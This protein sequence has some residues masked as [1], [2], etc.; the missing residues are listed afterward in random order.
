[1]TWIVPLQETGLVLDMAGNR[2]PAGSVIMCK[3]TPFVI[4]EDG[5]IDYVGGGKMEMFYQADDEYFEFLNQQVKEL[6]IERSQGFIKSVFRALAGSRHKR[7]RKQVT[8]IP[9]TLVT[10]GSHLPAIMNDAPT[11]KTLAEETTQDVFVARQLA[12]LEEEPLEEPSPNKELGESYVA[13]FQQNGEHIPLLCTDV[14]EHEHLTNHLNKQLNA[15]ILDT[16]KDLFSNVNVNR[17]QE[18]YPKISV[19][20]KI[21]MQYVEETVINYSLNLKFTQLEAPEVGLWAKTF[22]VAGHNED[23]QPPKEQQSEPFKPQPHHQQAQK[24]TQLLMQ[25]MAL[26]M[27]EL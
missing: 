25:Q 9:P 13:E 3:L 21:I 10:I 18:I 17:I 16:F 2:L 24:S 7:R 11:S 1:M 15:K 19:Y 27:S 6:H 26:L 23:L 22:Q 8:G 20:I 4:M 14:E 12:T 5:D